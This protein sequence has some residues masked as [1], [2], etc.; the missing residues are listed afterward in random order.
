MSMQWTAKPDQE[1]DTLLDSDR[2]ESLHKSLP[3][4]PSFPLAHHSASVRAVAPAQQHLA[5]NSRNNHVK[6][7]LSWRLGCSLATLRRRET[8]GSH[9]GSLKKILVS[10]FI[11]RGSALISGIPSDANVNQCVVV[12][13]F[14]SRKSHCGGLNPFR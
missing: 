5:A 6:V 1:Q 13:K 12:Y 8:V 10:F 11:V 3:R 9:I 7:A 2:Q 4:S 14:I